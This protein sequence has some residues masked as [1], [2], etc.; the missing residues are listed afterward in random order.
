MSDDPIKKKWL[1]TNYPEII[2]E[3]NE[4]GQLKKQIFDASDVEVDQMLAEYG[5]PSPSELGKAGCYIQ[6]TPRAVAVEKRRRNDIGDYWRL[7]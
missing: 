6:N 7:E 4:V 5:I 2:F 1:T 3:D